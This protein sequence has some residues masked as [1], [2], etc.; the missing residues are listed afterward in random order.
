MTRPCHARRGFTL[1]ELLVVIAIIAILIA[2][3]VP[4]VQRVRESAA[5]AQCQNNLKQLTLAVHSFHD[6][7]GTMPSYY[8]TYPAQHSGATTW[9][10]VSPTVTMPWGGWFLHLL[11]FVEQEALYNEIN[12]EIASSGNNR[13]STTG[14]TTTTQTVTIDGVT[15]TTTVT[16]GG[17]TAGAGDGIWQSSVEQYNFAGMR[18]PTD[19]SV[20]QNT[21]S[22]GWAVSNYLVNWNAWCASNGDG[23]SS[24]G[25]WAPNHL[26]YYTPPQRLLSI[27][28]GLSMTL[29]FGEGYGSCDGRPRIALYSPNYHNLGPTESLQSV[30][31]GTLLPGGNYPY[32]NYGI[33]NT[34]MFQVAPRPLVNAACP[35]GASCCE[36]W[37]AQTPHSFMNIAL[38]DGSV[39]SVGGD[40]SQSNWNYLL[41][42]RDS[43]SVDLGW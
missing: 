38:A 31:G 23:T 12:A 36:R 39:R 35:A 5:V 34:F 9:T 40:I 1:I 4:A 20:P 42:P 17:T 14:G 43:N 30:S 10:W 3:L 6:A 2:L 33:P 24:Y 28:D 7:N 22:S 27:T 41:L 37:K 21:I 29:L 8:G 26:G 25:D 11:P 18:C 16:T 13:P 32:G 15:Y 19:P